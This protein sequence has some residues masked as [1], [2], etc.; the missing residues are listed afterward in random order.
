MQQ[1]G[2]TCR[3]AGFQAVGK[4]Q[5]PCL[6]ERGFGHAL[7]VE[8]GALSKRLGQAP[9]KHLGG[10]VPGDLAVAGQRRTCPEK[11]DIAFAAGGPGDMPQMI[12]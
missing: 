2:R 8:N 12:K 4:P 1:K 10:R 9:H 11:I 6:V 3:I 7:T 5:K